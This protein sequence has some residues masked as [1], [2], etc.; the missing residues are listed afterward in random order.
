MCECFIRK[1]ANS[2][3]KIVTINKEMKIVQML[4]SFLLK[5]QLI[6]VITEQVGDEL[7]FQQHFPI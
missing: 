5:Y 4:S 2:S 3:I 6:I 7:N 1:T